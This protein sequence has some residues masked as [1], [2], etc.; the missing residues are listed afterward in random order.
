MP[1]LNSVIAEKY[2]LLERIGRGASSVVYK[3][4]CLT[5]KKK[6]RENELDREIEMRA[7]EKGGG[8][9]FDFDMVVCARWST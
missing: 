2:K 7:V 8:R 1:E 4:L 9:V 5:D 3:T 6:P